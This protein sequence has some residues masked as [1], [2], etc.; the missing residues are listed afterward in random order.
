MKQ[1][2]DLGNF[3]NGGVSEKFNL[4]L[5]KVLENIADPNT[6]P[7][8]ARKVTLSVT[9]KGNENRDLASV[10]VEAKSSLAPAKPISTEI[11]IDVATNGKVSGAELKSGIRGQMYA[12]ENGEVLDDRGEKPSEESPDSNKPNNVVGFK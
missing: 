9:L 7:S 6:D 12:D 5:Q 4:E 3:A 8:K 10:S 11:I 2:I 1:I